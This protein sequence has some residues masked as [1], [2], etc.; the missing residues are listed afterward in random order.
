MACKVVDTRLVS[1]FNLFVLEV[2]EAWID[3]VQKNTR[4]TPRTIHH[5]GYGSFLVDGR[6]IRLKSKMP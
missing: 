3:P 4:K 5:T 1:R 2:V 6:T